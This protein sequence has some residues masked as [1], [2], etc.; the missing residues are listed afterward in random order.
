M[1]WQVSLTFAFDPLP[2]LA[3]HGTLS[4]VRSYYILVHG[5]LQWAT[6]R[7]VA[8]EFGAMKPT[9]FYCHRYV[10]AADKAQAIARAFE[11]VRANLD[12]QMGWLRD[13]LA[14]VELEAQEVKPAPMH[15]L[16]KPDNR[17]HSF[18]TDE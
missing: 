5:K 4:V 3:G 1:L 14:T 6:D 15:K 17:G 7:S 8:D 2:T 16:L 18:Y 12:S 10:L 13:G 11:R 9:G